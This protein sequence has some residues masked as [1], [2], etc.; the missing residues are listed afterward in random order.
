MVL[1]SSARTA[2]SHSSTPTLGR[3]S[4]AIG[5][6]TSTSSPQLLELRKQWKWAAVSQFFYTFAPL[7][8]V[9]EVELVV[10]IILGNGGLL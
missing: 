10:C 5:Q 1:R 8:A 3:G 4:P 2:L 7:I 9:D 6:S